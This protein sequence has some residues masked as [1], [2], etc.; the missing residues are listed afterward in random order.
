MPTPRAAAHVAAVLRL[1]RRRSPG[2]ASLPGG[3]EA[4]VAYGELSLGRPA[5]APEP[6]PPVAV[7][8][9]GAW[10]V[11]GRGLRLV[12]RA[13]QAADGP[14]LR[15]GAV[16]WPLQVRTR[17]PGDRFRPRGGRGS[18]K[19]QDWLVDRKVPRA[20]RDGL[21]LLADASGRILWIPELRAEAAGLGAGEGPELVLA[22]EPLP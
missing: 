7:P 22:L 12:L 5:P 6:L 8:G 10:A 1:L 3:L 14:V 20:A 18:R 19:L 21:L 11:P 17:L 13:G 15:A 4:R 9:P 2:R 16:G